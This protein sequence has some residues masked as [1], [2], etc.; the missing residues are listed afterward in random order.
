MSRQRAIPA[1]LFL[2]KGEDCLCAHGRAGNSYLPSTGD[3][4]LAPR[5][6]NVWFEMIA[7]RK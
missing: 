7:S 6:S 5:G 4:A 1:V 2:K 3:Y